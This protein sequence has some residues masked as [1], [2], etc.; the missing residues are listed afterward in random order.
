M[1]RAAIVEDDQMY[2]EQMSMFLARYQKEKDI[3]LDLMM[4]EDGKDIVEQYRPDFDVIF[5]DIEMPLVNGMKAAQ[6]IRE[7][8]EHVILVFITNMAQYAIKAYEVQALDYIIK[9]MTYASFKSKMDRIV[10]MVERRIEK[11]IVLNVG[12]S[13]IRLPVSEIYY[14]E[15][16]SHNVIYHTDKGEYSLRGSL[17]EVEALL[18]GSGFEKCNNCFLVNL[19]HVRKIQDGITTVGKDQLPIS[20]SKKKSFMNAVASYI[21]N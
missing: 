8:D 16:V 1:I 21:G 9:P 12:T 4:Y 10:R 11:S 6:K 2:R 3:Q 13:M 18:E 17:K 14:V 5:L 7:V 15:V 19:R 20:R